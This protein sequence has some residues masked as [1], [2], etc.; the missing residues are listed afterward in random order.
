MLKTKVH[1]P[2][3]F[4]RYGAEHT[5]FSERNKPGVYIVYEDK[6]VVYVGYSGN[7]VYRTMYRHFQRWSDNTQYRALFNRNRHKVRLIYCTQAK[8]K[9]L[10]DALI[11]KYKPVYNSNIFAN[12]EP[13]K[14]E[15]TILEEY[16]DT[17][18]APIAEYKNEVPF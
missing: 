4:D 11:L 10:E 15:I 8:A 14:R 6:K 3:Y 12:F 9:K 5:F 18:F 7:N 1:A 2:Y 17:E 16:N 13:D